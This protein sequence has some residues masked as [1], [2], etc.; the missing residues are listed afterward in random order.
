ME[1]T[2]LRIIGLASGMFPAA[3][4]ANLDPSERC[5]RNAPRLI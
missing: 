2:I 1:T 5:A 4:A 3:R